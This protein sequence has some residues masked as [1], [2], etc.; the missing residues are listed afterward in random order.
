MSKD[1]VLGN[2]LTKPNNSP[3]DTII[4]DVGDKEGLK[5]GDQVLQMV[6]YLLVKL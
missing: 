6:I 2:I 3:Y 5:E 1:F 4:I